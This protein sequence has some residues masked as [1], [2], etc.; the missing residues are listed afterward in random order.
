MGTLCARLQDVDEAGVYHLNCTLDELYASVEQ[1]DFTLFEASMAQVQGKG[2]FLARS[3]DKVTSH[4]LQDGGSLV[5]SSYVRKS[6]KVFPLAVR[7]RGCP[8]DPAGQ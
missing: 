4:I 2:E 1:A 3:V 6:G 7:V 5:R 8:H